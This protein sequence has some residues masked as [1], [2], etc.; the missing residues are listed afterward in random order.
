MMEFF[1]VGIGGALGAMSRFFINKQFSWAEYPLATFSVN[2]IG[3]FLLGFFLAKIS[4]QYPQHYLILGVGFCGAFTTFSTFCFEIVQ[5]FQKGDYLLGFGY[6]FGSLII[7]CLAILLGFY[8]T[9][10]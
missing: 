1:L 7:G 8:L 9:K 5:F 3:S 6:L 10:L 4:M 2:I